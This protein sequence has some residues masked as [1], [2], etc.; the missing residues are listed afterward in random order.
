MTA[1]SWKR[2]ALGAATGGALALAGLAAAPSAH[3]ATI[4]PVSYDPTGA[5]ALAAAIASDP[6]LVTGASFTSPALPGT[7]HAVAT[8]LDGFAVDGPTFAILTTG[9][10][11]FADDPDTSES[12]GVD[13]GGSPVRGNTDRD[14]SI[15]KIDLELPAAGEGNCLQLDFAF[16]SDE[17]AEY[18]GTSYNDAFIAELDST[19]WTTS[20]S[21]ITAANN[22]AF[23]PNG[24]PITINAAGATA[25]SEA[26]SVGTTY[27]GATPLLTASTPASPGAHSLYL[28]IFDQGDGVWDSAA[29]V[30]NLRFFHVDDAAVDCVEGA[31]PTD[32]NAA[33]TADAGDDVSVPEGSTTQ[34]DGTGSSDPDGDTLAYGWSPSTNLD[35]ATS[36][37]PTFTAVDDATDALTL[38]VTDPSGAS[39]ADDVVVTTTNVAPDLT[40]ITVPSAPVPVGSS[41]P[42]SVTFTDPGTQDSHSSSF[43]WDDG[44]ASTDVTSGAGAGGAAAN[45]VFTTPGIYTVSVTTT[46]DDGGSDTIV[47]SSYVVVYDPSAGFVTGGGHIDSPAG[48]Y[49]ADPSLTG[50]ASFG[51]VSKYKK[52]ATAP[53]G[54]TEFQ[55]HAGDLNFHSSSYQWLVVAGSKAMY[56]GT[57]TVGGESGYS[58]LLSAKD[59]GKAGVDTFRIKIWNTATGAVVYDNQLGAADDAEATTPIT[60]GS[61]VVHAK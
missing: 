17:Y 22:F 41:V 2:R 24:E 23:G 19:T 30:D 56:K 34:L 28:S 35:D 50:K 36:A 40:A 51:F 42:V 13:L 7:P 16:Y 44:T 12:T 38:T 32:P 9:N 26:E 37:T 43:S 15:L 10:A 59:G 1:S 31:V 18:V 52:G 4:T 49:T 57:G 8:D 46:D 45:H 33:P 39:D 55:F 20:G 47:A 5:A 27:D 21:S 11:Q 6:A 25:M 48:A 58:F 54:S 53:E 61:I 3:A 29:F 60:S 14:V